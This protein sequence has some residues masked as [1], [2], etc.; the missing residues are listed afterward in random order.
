MAAPAA[1]GAAAAGAAASRDAGRAAF[2]G[3]AAFFLA[4]AA[5]D[6]PDRFAPDFVFDRAAALVPRRAAVFRDADFPA[7]RRVVFFAARAVFLPFF[8]VRVFAFFFTTIDPS[9]DPAGRREPG[10]YNRGLVQGEGSARR[11]PAA[12]R[13]RDGRDPRAR[14]QPL[15]AA[16]GHGHRDRRRRRRDARIAASR[17]GLGGGPAPG[18]LRRPAPPPAP[19][20]LARRPRLGSPGARGTDGAR[21]RRGED[22][23]RSGRGDDPAHGIRAHG[24]RDDPDGR[25]R[26]LEGDAVA[27]APVVDLGGHASGRPLTGP[28]APHRRSGGTEGEA[29][30]RHRARPGDGKAPPRGLRAKPRLTRGSPPR[31]SDSC[32]SISPGLMTAST[33]EHHLTDTLLTEY[34]IPDEVRWGI[35][36]A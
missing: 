31:R 36:D 32:G 23:G 8:A 34:S 6:A 17:P 18:R 7:A 10:S 28:L 16:A 29:G 25:A 12:R 2:R 20:P 14:R 33:T 13:R 22:R 21:L 1:I 30:H 35:A 19:L 4:F 26:L 11:D 9:S 5:R 24:R 15:V 27:A 3:A